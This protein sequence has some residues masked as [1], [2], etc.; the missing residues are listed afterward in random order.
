M[1]GD[2]GSN[3]SGAYG[4]R[5][6]LEGEPARL[7][8]LVR[9]S[10]EGETVEVTQRLGTAV[11]SSREV[12]DDQVTMSTRGGSLITVRRQPAAVDLLAPVSLTPEALVHPMLTAPFS[13]L[14]RWRGDVTLHGGAFVRA[15]GAWAVVGERTAGK[16]SLLGV[17][18]AQGIPIAADDLLAIDDGWLRAGP[19]CVDL[20]PDVAERIPAARD[21]GVV[22]NRPRFRLAAQAAPARSRLLG[23][24]VLEW[25]DRD[26]PE[27]EEVPT[28]ERLRVLYR[29]EAIALL[30]FAE[31]AKFMDLVGLPM[32]RLRRRRSWDSTAAA[33]E[34]LLA[35]VDAHAEA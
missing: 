32:L 30:G 1:H 28:V 12:R 18:A 25:H 27:L 14:A 22:G 19:S 11:H 10:D 21:L 6:V 24:I 9:V 35:V 7:P 5:L 2:N 8:D 20:R 33:V 13:M 34:R 4:F 29:Q 15:G 23:S 3:P 17:L 26:E 16:S 31:P